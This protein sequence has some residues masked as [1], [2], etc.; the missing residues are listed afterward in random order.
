MGS[1]SSN[2]L[3]IVMFPWFAFGHISPFLQLSNKLSSHGV[4]I[5]FFSASGN[6][7]RISLMVNNN[8]IKLIPLTLPTVDGLPPGSESTSDMPPHM[9]ELLKTCLDKMQPQIESLLTE[10]KPHFVF[11]D[12]CHQWVP[13]ICEKLGIKSMF[14]SVFSAISTAY[15]TNPARVLAC[16]GD[17]PSLEEMKKPPTG[18]PESNLLLKSYE[19]R[20]F[21]YVFIN[22]SGPGSCI[23]DRVLACML[24]C[25]AILIKSCVELE[26]PYIDFVK[27]Q[28]QKPVFLAGPVVPEPP[29]GSLDPKWDLWLTTFPSK[30]VVFCS[31]GSETFLKDEQIRQLITGLEITGLPFLV[32]LNFPPRE[33]KAKLSFAQ[34][35]VKDKERGVVY[36]GWVQQQLILAHDS[37]GCYVSHSGFSSVTEGITSDCQLVL[38]PQKGDQYL[39]SKLVSRDMK[40]GVEVNR[41]DEDGYFGKEELCK[42]VRSVMVDVEEDPGRT[43]RVNYDKWR[44]FFLEKEVHEGFIRDFVKEMEAMV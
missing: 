29:T 10:M 16:A 21:L 28:F 38:L 9:A 14:F 12:F 39:N 5:S 40:A 4:K 19:A 37:V 18:F 17:I 42:A 13:Q 24:S 30:S 11:F 6:I 44:K 35:L 41:R 2:K 32:V 25:S 20:D 33:E 26:G 43:I 31:F 1:S 34:N 27:T 22:F 3:H 7:P 15:L 23:Y 8:N 36:T